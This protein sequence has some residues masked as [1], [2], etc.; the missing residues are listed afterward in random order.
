M[1]SEA[2]EPVNRS[3]E[4]INE[5]FRKR[6]TRRKALGTG[7]KVA[8]GVAAAVIVA[9]GGTAAYFASQ[10]SGVTTSVVTSTTTAVSTTTATT[11]TTATSPTPTKKAITPGPVNVLTI[12]GPRWEQPMR[13]LLPGFL[14]ANPSVTKVNLDLQDVASELFV[15]GPL[16]IGQNTYSYDMFSVLREQALPYA[17][18]GHLYPLDDFVDDPDIGIPDLQNWRDIA[19]DYASAKETDYP[20]GQVQGY[21][22]PGPD[23]TYH[24]YGIPTDGNTTIAVWRDD[25]LQAAG[26]NNGPPDKL[27]ELPDFVKQVHNPPKVYGFAMGL[28]VPRYSYLGWSQFAWGFGGADSSVITPSLE[29]VC[30]NDAGVAGLDLLKELYQYSPPGTLEW[31]DPQ[32]NQAVGVTGNVAYSPFMFGNPNP[33]VKSLSPFADSMKS[34]VV[35]AGPKGR[36]SIDFGVGVVV[37][38]TAQNPRGAYLFGKY[39]QD[40]GEPITTYVKN[41]GQPARLS[42]LRDP[43]INA[44]PGNSY[45]APLADSLA[46]SRNYELVDLHGFARWPDIQNVVGNEVGNALTGKKTSKQALTDA[47][48][49]IEALLAQLAASA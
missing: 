44:I 32:L 13:A 4:Q 16:L 19:T 39:Q 2:E 1:P 49:G 43:T 23:G 18:A 40:P 45:F 12:S 47:R 9:G 20:K 22:H 27:E 3:I 41:T 7:G 38:N 30:D 31:F 42:I 10:P 34:R 29:V 15:R 46:V 14:A 33:F 48:T 28:L 24:I 6:M 26:I 25:I 8:I 37:H 11:T 35:P 17:G 21:T 5:L 36:F